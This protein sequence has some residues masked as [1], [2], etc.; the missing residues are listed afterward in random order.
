METAEAAR[1]KLIVSESSLLQS[2]EKV[3]V[4]FSQ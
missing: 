2:V 1:G 4:D 3:S